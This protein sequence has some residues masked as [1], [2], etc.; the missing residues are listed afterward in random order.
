MPS[1]SFLLFFLSVHIALPVSAQDAASDEDAS[2]E[3]RPSETGE[4][5]QLK[6]SSGAGEGEKTSPG[7]EERSAEVQK[8]DESQ[9]EKAPQG[10]EQQAPDQL[11][12]EQQ[13]PKASE[14]KASE[15]SA[16]DGENT[17]SSES[18]SGKIRFEGIV[19]DCTGAPVEGARVV[20]ASLGYSSITSLDGTFTAPVPAGN[21]EV[22]VYAEGFEPL[23]ERV[24]FDEA[25][26]ISGVELLMGVTMGEVVVTGTRTE[27]LR[28]QA[29]VRT[30]VVS[31]EKMEREQA[32]NLAEALDRTAGLRVENNCQNCNFTQVRMNGLEGRYT[33][34]MIDGRPVFSSLAGVYG[35]EQIPQE[36]IE[37]VEIVKGGGSA[38][39]GGNAVGGVINVIT[40][41]PSK[42]FGNLTLRNGYTGL[43]EPEYRLSADSGLIDQDRTF[44]LH[45]FGEAFSREPWDANGDGFSEVGKVR[46]VSAGA[47]SYLDVVENGELQFKFHVLREHRRG[48]NLFDRPEHD[49]GIT[50]GGHTMRQGGELDWKHQITSSSSYELGYGVAYTERDSYYGGGGDVAIPELPP[51]L[52]DLTEQEYTDFMEVWEAKQGAL[53]AY[54]RTQ[55]P[56]HTADATVNVI[57]DALGEMIVTTGVQ[58]L[59]DGL[60]DD[61]PAYNRHVDERYWDTA[62]IL[63]HDWLFSEWGESVVGFRIDRHSEIDDMILSPRAALM[64]TPLYWLRT[65]TAFSSGFRAPQVFDEDLHV[66]IV[67][68]EGMIVY[69]EE[70][71]DPERSYSIAQQVEL[72]FEIEKDWALRTSLNGFFTDITAAFVLDEVDDPSTPDEIEVY[73]RNRGESTVLGGELEIGVVY[74][75]FWEISGGWTY[76]RASSSEADP[77]FNSRELFRTPRMYG[78]M[79]TSTRPFGGLEAATALEITGPMKV[80]HYAGYIVENTLEESPWFFDWG[81]NLSYRYEAEKGV[82]FKPFVGIGNI[83]DSYQTDLDKGENRDAGYVYGPR[84]P[85]TFFAGVKGGI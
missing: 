59:S 68:G 46:E 85:R 30:Q 4:A 35:L 26:A 31:R 83:L 55:N 13:T 64:F 78:F 3:D 36:M 12:A 70:D 57:F 34:I 82:Y 50:E 27:K 56:V 77:D 52:S 32:T 45:M 7:W 67:G 33:Q 22:R 76:E 49:T 18:E 48:G 24:A 47:E 44:S 81:A 79:E 29:P 58:Y 73:R 10:L 8:K 65:R 66:T 53:G 51:T 41:R 28:E 84:L 6:K 11:E 21:Y 43:E 60:K 17:R 42:S 40:A 19:L 63:Q 9:E 72:N 25:A 69:N 62:G 2:S 14:T 39:Y 23:V 38:L 5:E 20:I 74:G 75:K 37:R 15:R 54:G 71:L 80:P 16:L 1:R 61:F